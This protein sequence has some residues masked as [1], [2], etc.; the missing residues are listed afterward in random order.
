MGPGKG[1]SFVPLE[2]AQSTYSDFRLPAPRT[3]RQY[4]A[5]VLTHPVCGILLK[6]QTN[7]VGT[8][9]KIIEDGVVEDK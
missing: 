1:A 9:R 2:G 3:V 7:I 4:I 6:Q 5:L 8:R